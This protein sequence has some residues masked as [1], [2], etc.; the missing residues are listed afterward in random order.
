ML[1]SPFFVYDDLNLMAT[2]RISGKQTASL[3]QVLVV[4]DFE[5]FRQFLRSTL[6]K[7]NDVKIVG[8][9]ADGLEAVRKAT[10]LRPDLILMDIGLPGVNGIEA[11]RRILSLFPECKI[12]F[13]TQEDSPEV[14]ET[15]LNL[16]AHGHVIKARAESDLLLAVDAAREGRVFVS[17]PV[18]GRP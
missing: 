6:C 8:E 13:V 17:G 14:V 10:E 12:V 3:L 2:L 16:G 11:A 5:P 7:R 18:K 9:A 4:E 1:R 15:A